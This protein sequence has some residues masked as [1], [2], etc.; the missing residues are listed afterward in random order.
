MIDEF[1]GIIS[2]ALFAPPPPTA[3]MGILQR[4]EVVHI[5]LTGVGVEHARIRI[6]PC[7]RVAV[8]GVV[9]G[10]AEQGPRAGVPSTAPPLILPK[11]AN[12]RPALA[13]RSGPSGRIA[14]LARARGALGR[15]RAAGDRARPSGIDA[16]RRARPSSALSQGQAANLF[17]PDYQRIVS[18][19][20]GRPDDTIGDRLTDRD[21]RVVW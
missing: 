12:C 13:S 4:H 2:L 10:R 16:L 20:P 14:R 11:T 19:T 17:S 18:A 15:G 7:A 3:A 1:I 21:P 9:G 5:E 8:Y 6:T